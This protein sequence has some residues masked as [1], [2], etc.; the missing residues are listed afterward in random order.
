[1]SNSDAV[2]NQN[3]KLASICKFLN[4]WVR[5][6]N[7]KGKKAFSPRAMSDFIWQHVSK[8]YAR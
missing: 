6:Q 7:K 2:K 3:L 1:M 4:I 5:N 8:L